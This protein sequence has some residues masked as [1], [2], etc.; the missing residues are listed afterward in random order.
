MD[1]TAGNIQERGIDDDYQ[2]CKIRELGEE[3]E[4]SNYW[5]NQKR[6]QRGAC[7]GI[8]RLS[9]EYRPRWQN[10]DGKS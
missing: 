3:P 5:K 10:G 2:I 1:A 9:E 6:G 8:L 4:E 7:A